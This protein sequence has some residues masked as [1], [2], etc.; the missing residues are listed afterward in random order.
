AQMWP[1]S[2]S[3]LVFEKRLGRGYFGEVWQCHRSALSKEASGKPWAVKKVPLS[4]IQQH[5]LTEQME[6]EIDIQRKLRHPFIV[7]L[8]FDFRDDSHVYL[9]MEFAEGG[10]MFD[11][12]SKSGRFSNELAAKYFF[13]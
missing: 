1:T 4:L 7:E 2:P 11:L 12:L 10:G 3:D 6:R 8:H 13:E 9:G 5:S